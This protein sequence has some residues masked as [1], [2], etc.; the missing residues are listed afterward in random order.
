MVRSAQLVIPTIT[1]SEI[2]S[3]YIQL[4][5]I[6]EATHEVKVEAHSLLPQQSQT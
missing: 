1:S 5:Y 4:Q 3:K 6:S 2:T